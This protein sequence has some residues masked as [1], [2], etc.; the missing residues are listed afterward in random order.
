MDELIARITAATGIDQ[1][2]AQKAV[3]LMLGFLK[4]EGPD[5][6]IGNGVGVGIRQSDTEL[7]DKFNA[8]LE[9]M[10]MDG[11]MDELIAKYFPEKTGG[12]FY[13]N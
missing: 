9:S 4:Q 3:G 7:R 5:I 12:P 6:L 13:G 10:K 1:D 8:A 11:T 2:M